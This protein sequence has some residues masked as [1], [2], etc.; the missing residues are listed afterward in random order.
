MNSSQRRAL[1]T[2]IAAAAIF[3]GGEGMP[4]LPKLP[5]PEVPWYRT[6]LP[7]SQ[8]KGKSFTELQ[9]LRKERFETLQKAKETT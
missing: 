8:R 9:S 1:L 7:R 3:S 4:S 6:H 2:T 5:E